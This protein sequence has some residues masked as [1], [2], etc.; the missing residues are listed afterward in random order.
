MSREFKNILH[1]FLL[2]TIYYLRLQRKIYYEFN[3]KYT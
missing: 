3:E 2:Y 1:E